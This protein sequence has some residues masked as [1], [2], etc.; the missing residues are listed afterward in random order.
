MKSVCVC[1]RSQGGVF[2][3][4]SGPGEVERPDVCGEVHPQ[5]GPEGEGEQHRERDRRAEEVSANTRA[6]RFSRYQGNRA[7]PLAL[8]LCL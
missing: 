1:L 8:S 5:E 4:G 6:H 2:R 3:S 7:S